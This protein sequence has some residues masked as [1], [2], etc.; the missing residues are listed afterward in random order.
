MARQSVGKSEHPRWINE[1]PPGVSV[2]KLGF[3]T[4]VVCSGTAE[5]GDGQNTYTQRQI[6]LIFNGEKETVSIMDGHY[7]TAVTLSAP[8]TRKLASALGALVR[9]GPMW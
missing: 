8:E 6:R 2:E 5:V 4:T 1:G 3:I 7:A 9:P